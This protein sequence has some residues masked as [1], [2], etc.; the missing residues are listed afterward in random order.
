MAFEDFN[1]WSWYN[2][3]SK[4]YKN[5][6]DFFWNYKL[7]ILETVEKIYNLELSCLP[8]IFTGKIYKMIENWL[9]VDWRPIT[10][11]VWIK[12][13]YLTAQQIAQL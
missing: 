13:D 1:S 3:L 4:A 12:T 10:S 7:S 11:I 5:I 2:W 6:K 8:T 9:E